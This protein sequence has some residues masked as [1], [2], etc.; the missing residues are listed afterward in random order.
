MKKFLFIFLL[1]MSLKVIGQ[2]RPNAIQRWRELNLSAE[3]KRQIRLIILKQ[4]LQQELDRA[5]LDRILTPDQKKKLEEWRGRK[6]NKKK[7]V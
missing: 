6:K 2:T 5:A 1:L 4:R 3:Q 7:K